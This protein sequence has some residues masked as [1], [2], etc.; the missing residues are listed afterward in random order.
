LYQINS[1]AIFYEIKNSFLDQKLAL[2][3]KD[4]KKNFFA[5]I[6]SINTE[7]CM[8]HL[9]NSKYLTSIISNNIARD[10]EGTIEKNRLF[11]VLSI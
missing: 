2:I 5:L 6:S 3:L 8:E 9:N 4:K 10:R 7:K 11:K 1:K